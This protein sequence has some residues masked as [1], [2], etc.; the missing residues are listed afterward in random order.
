LMM[1]PSIKAALLSYF[2]IFISTYYKIPSSLFFF[3]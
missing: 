1:K 2:F 3:S